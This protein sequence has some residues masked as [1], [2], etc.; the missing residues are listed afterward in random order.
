MKLTETNLREKNFHDELQ[1]GKS[2]YENSFYRALFNLSE[3]FFLFLKEKCNNKIVLDYGCGIGSSAEKVLL[4]NPKRL[5]GIDIS[6]VSIEKAKRNISDKRGICTLEV[7]NCE[8]TRFDNDEFDIIYGTGVLHHLELEKCL[9][10]IFRILKKDGEIIFVEPMGTNPLINLYRY[11]TPKSRSKD[12]H[13]FK[14]EDLDLIKKNFGE[15][16]IRYYGFFTILFLPLY[17]D[18][19]KS[20]VFNFLSLLDKIIFKL[21][22]LR[23][24]AWSVIISAKKA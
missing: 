2:R 13:P 16:E 19:K 8:K 17:K 22:F 23:F 3:D 24:L 1:S 21:N 20:N 10:E 15:V 11:L 9:K 5:N 7:D 14:R 6:N 4:F 12:E 18:S